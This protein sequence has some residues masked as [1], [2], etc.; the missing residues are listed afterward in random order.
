MPISARN[1]VQGQVTD[2]HAGEVMSLVTIQ[3]GE[4]RLVASVTNE[5]VKELQLKPKDSVTAVVKSTEVM[6]IKGESGGLKISARNKLKGQVASVQKGE[7]MGLVA[8]AVGSLHFGAAITRQAI[9]E[10]QLAVG[11]TVTVVIKAT[12]VM[13]MK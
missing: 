10:M 9:D 2:I 5:G 4:H 6:L 8:V 1:K 13:L 3:V 11:D 7:A 12:E